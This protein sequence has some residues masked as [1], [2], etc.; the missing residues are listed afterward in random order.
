L[1]IAAA[2]GRVGAGSARTAAAGTAGCSSARSA[3]ES[4]RPCGPQDHLDRGRKDRAATQREQKREQ[5]EQLNSRLHA[6]LARLRRVLRGG[7]ADS[8]G[9]AR[10]SP[11]FASQAAPGLSARPP[12]LRWP[13]SPS[14]AALARMAVV[15]TLGCLCARLQDHRLCP[16]CS[17][18]RSVA[19]RCP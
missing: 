2:I 1:P 19:R 12:R 6:G 16:A 3:S 10:P 11:C 15:A 18:V 14:P 17:Y 5:G 4:G 7:R 8:P 13:R 9:A